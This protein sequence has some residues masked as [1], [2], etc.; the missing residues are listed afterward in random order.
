MNFAHRNVRAPFDPKY[1]NAWRGE[2]RVVVSTGR[3]AFRASWAY[4]PNENDWQCIDSSKRINISPRFAKWFEFCSYY[5]GNYRNM[6]H[7]T[8]GRLTLSYLPSTSKAA[9]HA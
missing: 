8:V 6:Y 7:L 9:A 3:T 2:N 5:A 1:P 4:R